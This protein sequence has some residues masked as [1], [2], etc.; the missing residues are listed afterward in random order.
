MGEPRIDAPRTVDQLAWWVQHGEE[1]RL[2]LERMRRVLEAADELDF[3][4]LTAATGHLTT[5][6]MFAQAHMKYLE[7]RVGQY[8]DATAHSDGSGDA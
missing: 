5:R 6:Q 1:Q 7:A 3:L 4:A 2:E 8:L